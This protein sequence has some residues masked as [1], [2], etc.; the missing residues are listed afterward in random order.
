ML[1]L[2]LTLFVQFGVPEDPDSQAEYKAFMSSC[3]RL[4]GTTPA[5]WRVIWTENPAH[6]ATIGWSTFDP[7]TTHEVRWSTTPGDATPTVVQAS[8]NG[9]YIPSDKE[10]SAGFVAPYFH[11]VRLTELPGDSTIWFQI[12]SDGVASR[13]LHFRTASDEA[14]SVTFL[15]GGDSRTGLLDRC[16]LNAQIARRLETDGDI[17]FFSH[18]GDYIFDG[19]KW[20]DWWLW[21]TQ[22]ELMTAADGRVLPI[23][24][25]RGNHDV[26]P[27]YGQVFDDPGAPRPNYW[28]TRVG[29]LALVN[30]NTEIS[31][32]GDQK[33]W[34]SQELAARRADAR[35]VVPNYHRALFP[36]VKAPAR[37]KV[38]WVPLFDEHRADLVLE[39]DGH[40]FK[41]TV[42]IFEGKPDP[43]G[44][45][46]MGEGG[47][48]VPQRKPRR[49]LWY[50][51]GG[52]R[53]AAAHHVMR[54]AAT[55]DEL[56]V[57]TLG[58][59]ELIVDFEPKELEPVLASGS[60]AAYFFG[61]QPPPETWNTRG[62]DDSN[63][64]SGPGG[65]GFGD[66]DDRTVL[67]EM[68][69]LTPRLYLRYELDDSTLRG[70]ERLGLAARYDDGFIAYLNGVEVA[71]GGIESGHGVN[72]TGVANHEATRWE[73]FA[74]EG[75]T[76]LLMD[77]VNVLALEGHNVTARSKDFSLDV[78]LVTQLPPASLV[79]D[80]GLWVLDE[81]TIRP[82]TARFAR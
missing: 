52:G 37:A 32:A 4:E 68:H 45:V 67:A 20:S 78:A 63:W 41:R 36:A 24:P 11:H 31:A 28:T 30:L 73:H 33:Q 62:F 19:K 1:T 77:G 59:G 5:Q 12:V 26:G 75:H 60:S 29:S 55:P 46:Y 66:D 81:T 43:R 25:V 18:G 38:H 2:L 64:S 70:F 74:I 22:F 71:R 16:R 44:T 56:R 6:V 21:L 8:R 79:R 35:W 80:P 13:E 14:T 53:T 42:P 58:M 49:N 9:Q 48:G 57:T 15:A 65:F 76:D 7:G 10:T 27:I 23:V 40:V 47:L 3:T 51:E 82:A 54:I 69:K 72:A 50:F 34:M 39:S 17:L 61:E